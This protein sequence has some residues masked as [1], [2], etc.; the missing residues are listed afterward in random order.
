MYSNVLSK[1]VNSLFKWLTIIVICSASLKTQADPFCSVVVLDEKAAQKSLTL[2][3]KLLPAKAGELDQAELGRRIQ[4][5]IDDGIYWGLGKREFGLPF[6]TI[7]ALRNGL[8]TRDLILY[9]SGPWPSSMFPHEQS[10]LNTY[11]EVKNNLDMS[12]NG[13]SL[14]ALSNSAAPLSEDSKFKIRSK[15]LNLFNT[16]MQIEAQKLNK[17]LFRTLAVFPTALGKSQTAQKALNRVSEIMQQSGGE[18]LPELTWNV[19]TEEKYFEGVRLAALKIVKKV[20]SGEVP[21]EN[22]F[23]D[24]LSSYLEVGQSPETAN[25]LTWDVMAMVAKGGPNFIFRAGRYGIDLSPTVTV[26]LSIIAGAIPVLDKRSREG[27]HPY[28]LPKQISSHVDTGKPYHFWM[29]AYLSRH[30]SLEFKDPKAAASAAYTAA[31][32]YQFLSRTSGR[33]PE[34]ALTEDSFFGINNIIRGDL[35]N[36]AA[37]ARFGAESA[38]GT[39]E[40]IDL[41]QGFLLALR[42]ASDSSPISPEKA[43]QIFNKNIP[44]AFLKWVRR[45]APFSIFKHFN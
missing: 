35:V 9:V 38:T 26:G 13:D 29:T 2:R 10:R 41:D 33:V 40:S 45:F 25:Q 11:H 18:V 27:G 32:G 34:R 43:D 12:L 37:G 44:H 23:D 5:L 42:K 24:V 28:S 1:S 7:E 17:R 16:S 6:K 31:L 3:S 22:L 36:A 39:P 19:L 4:R 14:T 8:G 15:L 20:E 21:Q 30:L